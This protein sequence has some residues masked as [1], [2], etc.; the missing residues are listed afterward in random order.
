MTGNP[1]GGDRPKLEQ[2]Q[3]QRAEA[4]AAW[5]KIVERIDADALAAFDQFAGNHTT[6]P[7]ERE[8]AQAGIALG[9]NATVA[10]LVELGLLKVKPSA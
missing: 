8:A 6:P 5:G 9:R 10:V 3:Q 7:G 1:G 2:E 4:L